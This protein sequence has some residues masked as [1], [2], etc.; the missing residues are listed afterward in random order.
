MKR[1][2]SGIFDPFRN[3]HSTPQRLSVYAD[4]VIVFL[5]ATHNDVAVAKL[6]LQIFVGKSSVSP[7]FCEE[8]LTGEFGSLLNCQTAPP[9]IK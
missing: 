5:I 1:P 2:R 4:D 6:L 9:P 8:D 7:I 3:K